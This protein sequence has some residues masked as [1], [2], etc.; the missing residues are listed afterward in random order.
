TRL[1]QIL[2]NLVGNAIK[3][4]DHG[5]VSVVVKLTA[6][7]EGHATLRFTV[8]DTG[9]GIPPEAMQRLFTPFTQADSS[10][11]RRF[12]GSGLGLAI[13]RKL[14]E[15]MGGAIGVRAHPEGGTVFEFT[16]RFAQPAASAPAATAAP[17]FRAP[18]LQGRVLVVEDDRVNQRVIGHF[19]KQMKL[20]TGLAEDGLAAVQLGCEQPWDA[21]LMDLQLP[22]VDGIEATRRIRAHRAGQPPVPI[23]AIT[24]NASIQDREACLAAGM[25]DFITKPIRPEI[26]AAALQR[27]LPGRAAN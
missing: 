23:I 20:E 6:L 14:A 5:G 3:F 8:I 16:A 21:I 25:D 4:T 1:R 17:A 18:Q 2:I 12:G 27:W 19:L 11:S 9:I 26:L 24:A 22:G 7:A 15:A 10:M 13:C